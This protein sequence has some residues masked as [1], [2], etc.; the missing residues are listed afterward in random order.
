M[1]TGIVLNE[2]DLSI[3]DTRIIQEYI[4]QLQEYVKILQED[5]DFNRLRIFIQRLPPNCQLVG[6][7][8]IDIIERFIKTQVNNLSEEQWCVLRLV[9]AGLYGAMDATRIHIDGKR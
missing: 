7:T 9:N 2:T 1:G 6:A 3:Q 8:I 4:S 5:L